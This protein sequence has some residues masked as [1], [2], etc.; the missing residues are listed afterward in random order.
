MRWGKEL[1]GEDRLILVFRFSIFHVKGCGSD[2]CCKEEFICA[3]CR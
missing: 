3:Q 2:V 1:W